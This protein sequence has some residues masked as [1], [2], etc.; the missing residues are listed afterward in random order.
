[1]I[2]YF[3]YTSG[4]SFTLSGTDYKGLFNV[5]DDGRAFTGKSLTSLSQP[6][7]TK[8]TF[9]AN[10]F[11]AKKEFDRTF[12][13]VQ[14]DKVLTKPHI[15]PKD[16]IDQSFLNK[17]L[18]ILNDNNL[19]LYDLNILSNPEIFNF[20]STSE[21]AA[22]YVLALSSLAESKNPNVFSKKS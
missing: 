7:S 10:S 15:S 18:D 9:I 11:L 2:S 22:S 6:L 14:A 19:N 4:E 3:K 17:N 12:S 8:G 20:Q 16:I 1:M 21:D 5:T 13:L